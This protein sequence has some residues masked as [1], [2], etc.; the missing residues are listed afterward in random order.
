MVKRKGLDFTEY[1]LVDA[2]AAKRQRLS[3]DYDDP[4][5]VL[6]PHAVEHS[7][8]SSSSQSSLFRP[9]CVPSNY[10]VLGS[11]LSFNIRVAFK[12]CY[13]I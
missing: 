7:V 11:A 13:P 5:Y 12:A 10:S 1:G 3:G 9:A 2:R 4:K 8:L 6:S